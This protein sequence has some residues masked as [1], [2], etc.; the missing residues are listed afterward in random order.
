MRLS[1][2]VFCSLMSIDNWFNASETFRLV[3]ELD[4]ICLDQIRLGHH[5]DGG[6]NVCLAGPFRPTINASLVYSF[7]WET[8]TGI[9]L[10]LFRH[11]YCTNHR[12]MCVQN[13]RVRST[14]SFFTIEQWWVKQLTQVKVWK[15]ECDQ[16]PENEC[17]YECRHCTRCGISNRYW[18]NPNTPFW[19][20]QSLLRDEL[21]PD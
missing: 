10:C 9:A 14:S 15:H 17:S 18:T 11:K 4:V 16:W 12:S 1:L 5:G 6:W 21:H 19:M 7:G 8:S 13:E 2:R 20:E 3:E